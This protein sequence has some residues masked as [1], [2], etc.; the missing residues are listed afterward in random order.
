[1]KCKFCQAELEAN[2]SVCPK[3]GKDNLKDDLKP[4][5][6]VALVLV[7]LV[8]LVLLA[9]LVCYGVTGSFIPN[10]GSSST[11]P[12]G[13]TDETIDPAFLAAME[14]TAATMGDN[15]LTNGELQ[16]YYWICAYNYATDADLSADLSEQIYDETT[17]QTYHEYILELAVD[18]W[19]ECTLMVNAAKA[20]GYEMPADCQEYVDSMEEEL[21]YYV[22]IYSYY[23][24]LDVS[25]VDD[26]IKLQFGPGATY[27]DYY[28]YTWNY[29]YGGMYW[30]ELVETFE[31]TDEE[32]SNYFDENEESLAN[33]YTLS[34]TK[35]FGN[36]VDMRELMINVVTVE[37]TDDEGNTVTVED[38]DATQ[39][40]AQEIYDLFLKGDMTED[41]FTALVQ[42]HSE[43]SYAE[44]GGLL[45]DV[46]KGGLALVDVRHILIMPED[47]TSDESWAAALT[48][49]E[50]ILNQ[51]LAGDM[52]EDSFGE[53]ANEYSED[54]DGNVTNGG[55]Y[56]DV[57]MGQMVAAF[58]EWCFDESRQVGDYGIV[59]TEYGYHIMYFVHADR[60]MD[61]WCFAE[62][63]VSGD[64]GLLKT[65][66]GYQIVYYLTAEPAWIRYSRY[67][68]QSEKAA[69]QLDALIEANP[70]TVL[71]DEVVI[72]QL[73]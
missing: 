35:D 5:K 42:E 47:D 30:S 19:Q 3:C 72:G 69:D 31:A 34:I 71:T 14:K 64:V 17:G 1:M 12:T 9:G 50:D 39:A 15:T 60:E 2:S 16:I 33:D 36:L 29:Y 26:L 24:G 51:W 52:T 7:C 67:G 27:E 43:D 59:K 54:N 25:T 65:D 66:D 73:E 28:N 8:M 23:Y 49:A 37:Q 11:E 55:L 6:I 53:L 44:D 63:R 13:T 68:V 48:E 41:S 10:W 21:E 40:K 20:A 46:Y 4:L 45:T 70:Y 38:W 22:Y 62:G 56:S 57:Y 18:A 32:I 61:D 58:E